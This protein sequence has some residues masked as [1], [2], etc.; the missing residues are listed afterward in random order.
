MVLATGCNCRD[1]R[2]RGH[3]RVQRQGVGR[4]GIPLDEALARRATA[5]RVCP[6]TASSSLAAIPVDRRL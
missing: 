6:V 5:R 2:Q 4:V 3:L 1:Q